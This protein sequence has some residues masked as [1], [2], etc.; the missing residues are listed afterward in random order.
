MSIHPDYAEA[1]VSG[2]K[3]AEFRK[4]PL[5]ADIDVVLIYATAP[6]QAI[7][8]WFEVSGTVRSSPAEI[9][10]RLHSQGGISRTEF[11]TYYAGSIQGVA[12]LVGKVERFSELVALSVLSPRPAIP[13]SFSYISEKV[14]SQAKMLASKHPG[15]E[16]VSFAESGNRPAA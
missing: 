2:R 4:R 11:T 12:L 8:G 15:R 16:L 6:V 14:F 3:C 1:I 9:W 5:A 10:R 7:V 13:Q